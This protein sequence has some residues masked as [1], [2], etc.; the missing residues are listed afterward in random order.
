M[1]L[2]A[3]KKEVPHLFSDSTAYDTDLYQLLD[4]QKRLQDLLI[5]T[6]NYLQ[7]FQ[8]RQPYLE[9]HVESSGNINVKSQKIN[10]S[11]V[12][13]WKNNLKST[14]NAFD[15]ETPLKTQLLH[16]IIAKFNKLNKVLKKKKST[17][18]LSALSLLLPKEQSD[19]IFSTNNFDEKIKILK[20]YLPEK[21]PGKF[22]TGPSVI[23]NNLSSA[24]ALEIYISIRNLEKE[25]IDYYQLFAVLSKLNENQFIN[26]FEEATKHITNL[27]HRNLEFFTDKDA[28]LNR[29][30][31]LQQEFKKQTVNGFNLNKDVIGP[32]KKM[33]ERYV[34]NVEIIKSKI[35]GSIKLKEIPPN[36][37]IIRGFPGGDCSS[38]LCF[39]L[40][41]APNERI[42]FILD[43]NDKVKG[44]V[45]AAIVEAEG[46]K[47]LYIRTINGVKV[48]P[49]ET[50]LIL[51]GIFEIK[52]KIG[53]EQILIPNDIIH[54]KIMNFQNIR[55][56]FKN[57]TQGKKSIAIN[58]SDKE[59]R[60]II[61]EFKSESNKANYANM[62]NNSTAVKFIPRKELTSTIKASA[63][64]INPYIK[65]SDKLNKSDAFEFIIDMSY[66]GRTDIMQQAIIDSGQNLEKIK[67]AIVLLENTDKVSVEDYLKRLGKLTND[68]DLNDSF[69][70]NKKYLTHNGFLKSHDAFT[71]KNLEFTASQIISS[72]KN[73]KYSESTYTTEQKTFLTRSKVFNQQIEKLLKKAKPGTID[74][75]LKE[76]FSLC[77]LNQDCFH[78][79]LKFPKQYLSKY[80]IFS[81]LGT[82]A[83]QPKLSP[84]LLQALKEYMD[85]PLDQ[86][87]SDSIK[88]MGKL[89]INKWSPNYTQIWEHFLK[90]PSNK[91]NI[92][93]SN[94]L[95]T[96]FISNTEYHSIHK[97][98]FPAWKNLFIQN[99]KNMDKETIE[100]IDNSF[101]TI[102]DTHKQVFWDFFIKNTP[103]H[104]LSD[105]S[106]E[107]TTDV[108][109]FSTP[110]SKFDIFN[111]Q[112][113][114]TRLVSLDPK[115]LSSNSINEIINALYQ[116]N[117]L[118]NDQIDYS[119]QI[120]SS[121][122]NH[123]SAQNV[124][125][126][127]KL[128]AMLWNRENYLQHG[129]EDLDNLNYAWKKILSLPPEILTQQVIDRIMNS[130]LR[131]IQSSSLS[132]KVIVSISQIIDLPVDR[133]SS[134]NV[135]SIAQILLSANVWTDELQQRWEKLLRLPSNIL[136]KAVHDKIIYH[137]AKTNNS[138]KIKI[139]AMDTFIQ[140]SSE[141]FP[142]TFNETFVKNY[143]ERHSYSESLHST[144]I[145]IDYS[146]NSE[147]LEN[148][149]DNHL[150]G[151]SKKTFF[152]LKAIFLRSRLSDDIIGSSIKD[153]FKK[154]SIIKYLPRKA[155]KN[156]H[157]IVSKE[158]SPINSIDQLNEPNL[159]EKKPSIKFKH[160]IRCYQLTLQ[161]LLSVE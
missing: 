5:T 86:L 94:L 159:K 143:L 38:K 100:K 24:K 51:N 128:I 131:H 132:S 102:W 65:V 41:N 155:T 111:Q 81:I 40:P 20:K 69:F 141:K 11:A 124:T 57:Y 26:D 139:K 135:E 3:L 47:S 95:I 77:M 154:L 25:L 82:I 136:S 66:S 93:L 88:S 106:Q 79:A 114:F 48:T 16:E 17:T 75:T 22:K 156:I 146:A 150:D 122:I 42:Y 58:Y 105:I 145:I 80:D 59:Y 101:K 103:D 29:L 152:K 35:N 126:I 30:F 32:V 134:S 76:Y 53:V 113:I 85:L 56:I 73:G 74:P 97:S 123:L 92:Q 14:L 46:K 112:V 70:K 13:D 90:L 31:L 62:K 87:S 78:N 148:M 142:S 138:S 19:L 153:K 6:P 99:A 71:E 60:Q 96:Q 125:E 147:Y 50:E 140:Y 72:I 43:Q 144:E 36:L 161:N 1:F 21:L 104:L 108:I 8:E 133:I 115:K 68:L 28:L 49:Q 129:P 23:F 44:Y 63:S 61:E 34:K 116:V 64:E 121:S 120:I 130:A 91:L 12:T 149:L 117:Q 89:M 158:N 110:K 33:I 119:K 52:E 98:Y 160:I 83:T 7:T 18:L 4:D 109:N 55:E 15:N 39:A 151:F 27:N 118:N 54:D 137:F 2:I 9:M 37:G 107:I 10:N 84:T 127:S 45:G 67:E 157:Q